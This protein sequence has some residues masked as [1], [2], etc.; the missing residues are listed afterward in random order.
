MGVSHL[1][2]RYGMMN[3]QLRKV[4]TTRLIQQ[5]FYKAN[6]NDIMPGPKEMPSGRDR[7]YLYNASRNPPI[8]DAV[9]NTNFYGCNKACIKSRLDLL[10]LFHECK[11]R[12][13]CGKYRIL[14]R[15]P[16][17]R[18]K[19]ETDRDE[20][21]DEAWGLH[22]IFGVSFFRV[23]LYHMLILVGP[24]TFW[25]LWLKSW[26]RDWQNASVPFFAMMGLFSLFW[27]LFAHRINSAEKRGSKMKAS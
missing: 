16:K 22:V 24:T 9:F 20:E 2:F 1:R 11:G 19:W 27:F 25:G 6:P 13:H 15:L 23:A 26:P 3:H 14:E 7:D 21:K 8:L 5:K 4:V 18:R 10:R 12:N 17:R